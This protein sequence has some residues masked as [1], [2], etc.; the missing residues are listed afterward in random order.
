MPEVGKKLICAAM[1]DPPRDRWGAVDTENS[2]FGTRSSRS[3]RSLPRWTTLEALLMS[4]SIAGR[5]LRM[6]PAVVLQ[7]D[8]HMTAG[9][10]DS[11]GVRL[12]GKS[13]KTSNR[14]SNGDAVAV[15]FAM[16]MR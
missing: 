15:V 12:H 2:A 13:R 16:A 5:I 9:V 4:A 1:Q 10:F 7:R 6:I 3:C 8:V 14:R 11:K